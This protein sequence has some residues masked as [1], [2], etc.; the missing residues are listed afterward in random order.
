MRVMSSCNLSWK[1]RCG[2]IWGSRPP[3]RRTESSM[4][5]RGELWYRL[6][7]F[8]RDPTKLILTPLMVRASE[9]TIASNPKA[10]ILVRLA[11]L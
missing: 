3:T 10:S 4:E 1:A 8:H 7:S 5:L 2:S 6:P 11:L 9:K